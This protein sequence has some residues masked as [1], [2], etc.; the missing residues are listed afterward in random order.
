MPVGTLR[1]W[2]FVRFDPRTDP[3]WEKQNHDY[4]VVFWTQPL[5]RNPADQY[6]VMWHAH[7]HDVLG[8]RDVHEVIDW[9]DAEARKRDAMYT[10]FAKVD[11]PEHPGLRWIAGIDPT[12]SDQFQTFEVQRDKPSA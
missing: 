3:R 10:L 8:A 1:R 9:A 11:Y 5:A 2:T 12:V 6:R 4:R 7:E